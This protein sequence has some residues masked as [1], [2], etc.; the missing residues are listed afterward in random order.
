MSNPIKLYN[1][2]KSGHAHRIE[3]MLSL[4]NLPTE[5]VFV[6]LAKG[7]HKQPDFLALN[8]FGQVPVIDDNG[9]VIADSNAIL[10]YLAK[11]Y[12]NGTWL[13]EEPAA[14]ARVQRWLSVAAGPLAFGPAAGRLVTVFGAAFNTDEVI[15]RAH[16]LLKVI[17]AELATAPFLAGSTPT[18]ADIANYSYIAHAPEG[19]VSLEPYANVRSWLARIESL[20]GFV[21][22]PRTVIGLQT[23][24]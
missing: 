11:K 2:P 12:D 18:I 3:L 14:A 15:A 17:D 10:V 9:T 1:F 21:A 6:D 24:A 16:T 8:P 4:L 19:N 13:P 23:S 20:P 7:A 22:M 5:L